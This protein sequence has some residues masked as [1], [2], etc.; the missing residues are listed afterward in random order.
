[1]WFQYVIGYDKQEQ[2]SLVTSLRKELLDWRR[3]SVSGLEQLR[4]G[5]PFLIRPVLIGIGSL[6][7]VIMVVVLTRRVRAHGWRRGLKVWQ[8]A[9]P[10][11]AT[12]VE[13]YERLLQVLEKQGITRELYQTPLEFAG[14]V[15][16]FEAQLITRAYNRVR[17]GAEK[18]TSSE[19]N[20]IEDLLT[21]VEQRRN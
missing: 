10:S 14:S 11:E 4:A 5:L 18:L 8:A 19:R 7:A 21:R 16:V 13:F 6:F 3:D 1:M 9:T 12:R 2:R 17:F 15:A 20:E